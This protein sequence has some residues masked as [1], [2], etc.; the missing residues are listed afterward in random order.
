MSKTKKTTT[1]SQQKSNKNGSTPQVSAKSTD[2]AVTPPELDAAMLQQIADVRTKVHETF[3]KVAL[4]MTALPRYKNQ[5]ISDLGHILL[6]PLIRDRVAIASQQKDEI[7]LED[8]L[9]GIAIW[10]SVSEE[11]DAK[12][13]EQIKAGVFPVRLKPDDWVSGDINWLL[14]VIAPNQ[15][16]TTSVIA[17]FRQVIKEG[18]VRMHPLV[19]RLVDPEALKK[20]GAAP[21]SSTADLDKAKLDSAAAGDQAVN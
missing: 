16:L 19:A 9:T 14:D 11:V 17:N 13:R 7:S 6:N 1:K 12:I 18:D 10:A 21:I 3:G 5:S 2:G 15:K 4:A 20:M 8:S